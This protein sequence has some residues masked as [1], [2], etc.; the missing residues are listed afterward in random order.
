MLSG[1]KLPVIEASRV[2][3]RHLEES[4]T[5]SLFEIFSDREALR[6][7]GFPPYGE[8]A[9]AAKLLAEIHEYFR[10]KSLFQWGIALADTDEVIGTT[11]LFRLDDQ[12]RRAEIGYILNRRF[13]GGGYINEALSALFDF[14]FKEMNLHRIEADIEPRN[15]ASIK[16]VERLGFQREGFLRERWIV[17]GELHDSL[18][19][20]LL[21][22]DWRA[23]KQNHD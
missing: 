20:G 4:D 23:S 14:A 18:F 5:D 3:L 13:W 1:E 21:E 12:S 2:R 6:Y 10:Q 11:T 22:S 17:G 9:Q 7:W 15:S 16:V 19:Y 8:R